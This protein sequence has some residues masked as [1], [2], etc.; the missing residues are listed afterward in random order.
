[1]NTTDQ[2]PNRNVGTIDRVARVVLGLAM[3]GSPLAWYGLDYISNWGFL[4]LIP[5]LTGLFGVCPLY[6]L[7]GIS[8]CKRGA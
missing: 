7:L 6:R 8:T 2:S 4:G 3:L 5:L 1:M